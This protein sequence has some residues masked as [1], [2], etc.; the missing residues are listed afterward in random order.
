MLGGYMANQN[1]MHECDL[2][3]LSSHQQYF[4]D[5]IL[6]EFAKHGK[7]NINGWGIGYYVN[8]KANVLRS[9]EPA[10][11][12]KVLNKGLSKEFAIAIQ[13]VS[14]PTILGHLRLTSRGSDSVKNNH[15]F[16]L[17]FLDYDWMLIHNGTSVRYESLVPFDERLIIESNNDTP[18]IFEFMRR[19][20]I[21]YVLSD[22]K[23]S[24]IEACRSAYAKLLKKDPDGKFNIILTN[25]KLN[26]VFIHWRKFYILNR[27][28]Y[29]GNTLLITTLKNLSSNEEWFEFDRLSRKKAK[30]LV[31]SGNS[32]IFNGDIPK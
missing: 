11:Q 24:L 10:F 26:F 21:K 29:S 12:R 4:A 8:N 18:R 17:S 30:M 19:N 9:A 7:Q 15:P 3:L 2:F 6:S 25:G 22:T 31:F 16:R 32:L 14:S 27:D 23:R 20:I 13:A 1:D 5:K 28:K